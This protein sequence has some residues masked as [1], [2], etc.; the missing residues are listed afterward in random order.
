MRNRPCPIELYP[1]GTGKKNPNRVGFEVLAHAIL[2]TDPIGNFRGKYV[3]K[4]GYVR[5]STQE[6]NTIRQE[7]LM[8]DLG[9]DQLYVGPAS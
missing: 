1:N 6:Q 9:V 3:L 7:I 8:R 5:V 4:I 2:K